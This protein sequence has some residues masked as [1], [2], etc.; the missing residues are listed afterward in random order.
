MKYYVLNDLMSIFVIVKLLF[1]L[2]LP[3]TINPDA[4]HSLVVFIFI[5]NYL[6]QRRA[7][8]ASLGCQ[9]SRNGNSENP[10]QE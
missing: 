1:K 6:G 8:S 3:C 10:A 2:K 7:N 9:E 4:A 5:L